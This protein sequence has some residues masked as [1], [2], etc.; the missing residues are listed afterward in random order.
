M[1][2]HTHEEHAPSLPQSAGDPDTDVMPCLVLEASPGQSK[3][4]ITSLTDRYLIIIGTGESVEHLAQRRLAAGGRLCIVETDAQ[5]RRVAAT[6]DVPDVWDPPSISSTSDFA[7]R[8]GAIAPKLWSKWG[9][10]VVGLRPDEV[11]EVITLG[12]DEVG[13]RVLKEESVVWELSGKVII[14]PSKQTASETKVDVASQDEKPLGMFEPVRTARATF[15]LIAVV[16]PIFIVLMAVEKGTEGDGEPGSLFGSWRTWTRALLAIQQ[17]TWM[18]PC[19]RLLSISMSG[20]EISYK[21]IMPWAVMAAGSFV[22]AM[23]AGVAPLVAIVIEW[24]IFLLGCALTWRTSKDVEPRGGKRHIVWSMIAVS[25]TIGQ[26]SCYVVIALSYVGISA[27]SPIS[28]AIFLP[29]VCSGAEMLFV[30]VANKLYNKIVR[31]QRKDNSSK[32]VAGD[33]K[34]LLLP[35]IVGASHAEAE[36]CRLMSLL[37]GAVRG[38]S[39]YSWGA[40]AVMSLV[41]NVVNRTGWSRW[42]CGHLA[43][44]LTGSHRL[45]RLLTPSALTK[46][47]DE[48]KFSLGYPRFGTPVAIMLA[49]AIVLQDV[50]PSSPHF[51]AFNANF[52]G[53]FLTSILFEI[54]EDAI[55]HH[56]LVPVPGVTA[57]DMSIFSTMESSDLR[58]IYATVQGSAKSGGDDVWRMDELTA[59]GRKASS[60]FNRKLESSGGRVCAFAC[61]DFDRKP[62]QPGDA[63]RRRQGQLRKMHHC[64]SLHG[65]RPLTLIDHFGVISVFVGLAVVMSDVLFGPG[66]VK[67]VCLEPPPLLSTLLQGLWYGYPHICSDFQIQ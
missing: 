33:Q 13:V 58:S 47:H 66:Y 45:R 60:D 40:C 5:P 25:M 59:A 49:R 4:D 50:D 17:L 16:M 43:L 24:P 1:A 55:V 26:W 34:R 51:F 38:S 61:D 53:A 28:G 6:V 19:G 29:L 2:G 36:S 62:E 57:F 64:A 31:E 54:L 18:V 37:G 15:A 27:V 11:L 9:P 23:A 44:R 8:L 63:F 21:D 41:L 12:K 20:V 14:S 46:L 22:V 7:R 56:D 32:S 65:L 52:L 42:V 39:P 48:V 35:F 30:S 10:D 67:G 3:S